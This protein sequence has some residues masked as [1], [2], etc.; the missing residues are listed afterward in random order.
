MELTEQSEDRLEEAERKIAALESAFKGAFPDGDWSGHKR[1]HEVQIE[2]LLES[3][4][5]RAV[6]QE[7]T[8]TGLVWVML[9]VVG[10]AL[11]QWF[12]TQIK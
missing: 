4:R 12:K 11:W 8:I 3:R 2:M 5:L 7:K 1:Y 6:I 9:G 10:V